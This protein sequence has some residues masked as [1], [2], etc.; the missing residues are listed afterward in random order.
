MH[1]ATYSKL[2]NLNIINTGDFLFL[3]RAELEYWEKLADAIK[4][5]EDDAG[6]GERVNAA[7]NRVRNLVPKLDVMLV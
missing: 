6:S 5:G 4:G 2:A 1:L 3:T 7:C